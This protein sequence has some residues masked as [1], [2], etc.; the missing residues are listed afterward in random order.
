[1]QIIIDT[2]FFKTFTF[3][4]L[5]EMTLINK[6]HFEDKIK[7][8]INTYNSINLKDR[9]DIQYPFFKQ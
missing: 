6:K 8:E 1:M 9:I 2:Y 7:S 3:P 5:I 4:W